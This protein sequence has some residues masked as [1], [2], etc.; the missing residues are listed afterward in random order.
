[1]G[2]RPLFCAGLFLRI[3][4]LRAQT[5]RP[6]WLVFGEAHHLLPANWGPASASL[7]QQLETAL[8]ITVHPQQISTE[9]LRHVNTVLATGGSASHALQ[10]FAG[11]SGHR[12]PRP[13]AGA[14]AKG[15]VLLWQADRGRQPFRVKV[16]PG[17]AQ[18]RRHT[19]KYAEGLLIPE[20]SF[21][22]RGPEGKLNL[23]AHN[24]VLFLKLAEGVDDDTWLYHLRRGDY[25]SWFHDCI[26]DKA[27]AAEAE[28]VGQAKNLS[29]KES[30]ARIRQA[31]ADRYTLPEN[32]SLP[33]VTPN[34]VG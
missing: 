22:F 19:P 23:R 7:P 1:M 21:Y 26:G 4:E 8:L 15:E 17:H 33:K 24:L 10:A 2:D 14:A 31:V 6:H 32:P 30:R 25:S 28:K 27:L 29:A 13:R 5:G 9:A 12:P 20:R 16:E 11:A 34:Q 3:Q 18:H